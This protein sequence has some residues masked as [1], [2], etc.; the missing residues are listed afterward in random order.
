MNEETKKDE[1]NVDTTRQETS[2][3][4]VP[5]S[6]LDGVVGGLPIVKYIDKSSPK[7]H[8]SE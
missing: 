3:S 7:L 6:K 1:G 8:E 4:A 2:A 5:D